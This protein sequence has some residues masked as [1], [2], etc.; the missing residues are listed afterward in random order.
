RGEPG[1][2]AA[3]YE[4][5]LQSQPQRARYLVG[6]AR[7]RHTEGRRDEALAILEDA[8]AAGSADTETYLLLGALALGRQDRAAA[9]AAY[10]EALARTPGQP[11]AANNLAVLLVEDDPREALRLAKLAERASPHDPEIQDTLGV[12]LLAVGEAKAARRV[13]ARAAQASPNPTIAYHYARALVAVAEP[14]AAARRLLPLLGQDFPE[15]AQA[16]R[17]HAKLTAAP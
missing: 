15:A 16:R 13:L 2:A 6:L 17:L 10:R 9:M 7:A 5:L 11:L 1:A 14:A 12:A 4:R 3:A 8:A